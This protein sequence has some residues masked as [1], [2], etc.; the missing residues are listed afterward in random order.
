MVNKTTWRCKLG[1]E[2]IKLLSCS[3]QQNMMKLVVYINLK[4]SQLHFFLLNIAQ[5]ENVSANE[6]EMPTFVAIFIFI[7]REKFHFQLS[8][9]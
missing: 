5:H 4:Y 2:V 7:S 6:Y 9:A 1:P 8:L 3:T